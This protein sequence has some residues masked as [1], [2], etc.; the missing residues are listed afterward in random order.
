MY[1]TLPLNNLKA[2]K[3]LWMQKSQ[4]LLFVLKWSYFY[5]IICVTLLLKQCLC[6]VILSK[7]DTRTVIPVDMPLLIAFDNGVAKTSAANL[8]DFGNFFKTCSLFSIYFV[9]CCP[10]LSVLIPSSLT[11]TLN[12]IYYT[13]YIKIP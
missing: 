1:K 10:R 12:N 13:K 9:C 6:C 7:A 11:H 4:C 5:Y 8:I 3:K 2:T